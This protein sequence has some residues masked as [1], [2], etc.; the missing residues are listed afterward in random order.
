MPPVI[1]AVP[2]PFRNM[3]GVS[4]SACCS[5]V[6]LGWGGGAMGFTGRGGKGFCACGVVGW[7]VWV[8]L[9][10]RH[11]CLHGTL[12]AP[13]QPVCVHTP[14]HA[15]TNHQAPPPIPA[16]RQ[17]GA[18]HLGQTGEADHAPAPAASRR[19]PLRPPAQPSRPAC[20]Y[21][22]TATAAAASPWRNA[23]VV[24]AWL[25]GWIGRPLRRRCCP[26]A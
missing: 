21:V 4:A 2:C 18:P 1:T 8:L 17:A 12:Q 7:C 11:S 9:C 23:T 19:A 24:V 14:T 3:S 20:C 15:H 16:G 10:G 22:V 26:A 25:T 6:S 13:T 5:G